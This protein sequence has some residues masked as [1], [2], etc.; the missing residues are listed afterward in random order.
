M[1]LTLVLM[2]KRKKLKQLAHVLLKVAWVCLQ[3]MVGPKDAEKNDLTIRQ[4]KA[5]VLGGHANDY[6]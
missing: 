1:G 6:R 3:N 5:E 4:C 2:L